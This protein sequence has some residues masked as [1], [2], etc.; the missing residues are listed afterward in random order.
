GSVVVDWLF[1]FVVVVKDADGG[2]QAEV[3]RI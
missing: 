2:A 1:D 3:A